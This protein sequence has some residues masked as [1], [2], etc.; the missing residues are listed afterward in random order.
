MMRA[1][2]RILPSPNLTLKCPCFKY[3]SLYA[4][5]DFDNHN[6]P[7]LMDCAKPEFLTAVC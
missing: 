3:C 4:R 7:E 5:D 1:Y 6:V 2:K